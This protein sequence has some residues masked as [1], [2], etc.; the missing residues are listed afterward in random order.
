MRAGR[1]IG[2]DRRAMAVQGEDIWVDPEGQ[3]HVAEGASARLGRKAGSYRLVRSPPGFVV[4]QRLGGSSRRGTLVGEFTDRAVL[5]EVLQLVSSAEWT[6]ALEVTSEGVT[7]GVVFDKGKV[8]MAQSTLPAERLGEVL[9]RRGRVSREVLDAVLAG[10]DPSRRVGEALV[11][12]GVLRPHDVFAMLRAQAE[13]IFYAVMELS[14][15]TFVF[16]LGADAAEAPVRLSLPARHLLMEGVRRMDEWAYFRARIPDARVVPLRAAPLPHDADAASRDVWA[17]IDGARTLGDI[18]RGLGLDEF[19]A[20]RA[21]YTLL[22][23]GTAQL[24]APQPDRAA[25]A[26]L[27]EATNAMLRD[28]HGAVDRAGAGAEARATLA[29]FVAGGGVLDA[30]LRGTAPR[31]D[32]A[33]DPGDLAENLA[34]LGTDEPV[35]VVRQALYDYVTF[36]L[37]SAGTVLRRED[38]HEL[39]RRVQ[40]ALGE[41]H[42]A[43]R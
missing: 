42:L 34:D 31:P 21:L 1:W 37:F 28:V 20:T 8:T 41:F 6:G 18:A 3:V 27:V 2:Y 30:L 38:Y 16:A 4:L 5:I 7:R 26:T 39:A 29:M 10:Q 40:D 23:R 25:L 9:Y 22:Q 15:G 35:E 24:R 32:G 36:A 43:G 13:E 33:L 17:Q 12:R 19:E 14:E 11:D